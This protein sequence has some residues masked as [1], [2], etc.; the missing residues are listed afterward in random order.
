MKVRP[1]YVGDWIL[2]KVEV[3]AQQ[4]ATNKLTPNQEGPYQI[5]EETGPGTFRLA[6]QD[7][8]LLPNPWHFDHL[9]KYFMQQG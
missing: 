2:R 9:K 1:L 5:K 6:K 4:M 8:T 3:T 7:G